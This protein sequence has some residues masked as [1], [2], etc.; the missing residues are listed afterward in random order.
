MASSSA[1]RPPVDRRKRAILRAAV[2][3][4]LATIEGLGPRRTQRRRRSAWLWLM[5]VTAV[6][7][8]ILA[9]TLRSTAAG[10]GKLEPGRAAARTP[11]SSQAP[12]LG[13]P[14]AVEPTT[15]RLAVKRIVLDPGHG[16]IDPGAITLDLRE[17]DITLDITRRVG[18]ALTA[19]GFEVVMTRDKDEL[20]SLNQRV[21]RANEARGDL[22]LSIHVNSIP[23]PERRGVE[24]YVVG[25]TTD[26][27]VVALSRAENSGSGYSL[28][29]F[30]TLLEAVLLDVRHEESHRFGEAVQAGMFSGLRRK[31][32]ELENRGVKQAPFVVLIGADM[33]GV[34]AEVSCLSNPDDVAL[35][36]DGNYRQTIAEAL[37]TGVRDY[38]A[39]CDGRKAVVAAGRPGATSNGP[40]G[41]AGQ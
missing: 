24:T 38:A 41:W 10:P 34:L 13:A 36:R 3:D 26:P 40:K 14:R 15:F 12:R 9:A 32:P 17:K 39:S 18:A 37:T 35:L 21:R 19:A 23:M 8:L 25:T 29:D 2:A 20:V 6:A 4:N 16:G 7:L 28:A 1:G 22:F 33:P 5:P 31:N 27:R 30:R 11:T